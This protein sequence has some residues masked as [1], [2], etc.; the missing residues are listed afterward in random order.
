L[1][2]LN[3]DPTREVGKPDTSAISPTAKASSYQLG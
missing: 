1:K 2:C 3:C